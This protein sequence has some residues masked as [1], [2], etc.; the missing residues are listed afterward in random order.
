ME[1]ERAGVRANVWKVS[2]LYPG[3]EAQADYRVDA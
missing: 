3:V 2:T 1:L